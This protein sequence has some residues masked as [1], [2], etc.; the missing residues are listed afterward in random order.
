MLPDLCALIVDDEQDIREL[1]GMALERIDIKC[2]QA[3]NVTEATVPT[4]KKDLM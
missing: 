2:E 4:S 3:A 1:I